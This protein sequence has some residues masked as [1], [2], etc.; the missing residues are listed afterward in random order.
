MIKL[1]LGNRSG[2]LLLLPFLIALYAL[3]ALF[4]GYHLPSEQGHFGFWN[5]Y[6]DE[7]SLLSRMSAPLLIFGSATLLN[8]LFN[9]NGFH[10][11]NVFLPSLIYVVFQSFFHSFYFLTGIGIATMFL[12]L[13]MWQLLKLDQ[14]TDGRKTVFNTAILF[15]IA[16]TFYPMLLLS[17]PFLFGMIWILRPFILRESGLAIIGFVIPLLYAGIYTWVMGISMDNS[18]FSSVSFEWKIPDIYVAGGAMVLIVLAG[19]SP[20]LT[21]INQSSIRL[22]KIFRVNAMLLLLFGLLAVIEVTTNGKIDSSSLGL[23][24]LLFIIMYGFGT[25]NPRPFNAIV[26][27]LLCA[28]SVSKFFISFNL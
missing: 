23:I 8:F 25:K 5:L 6:I 3:C 26:F 21:K 1:F 15:G 10:E 22:K 18:R 27:Y 11:K 16:T 14:N 24:P 2:V 13:A 19:L 9:R 12:I 4:S 20:L 7:D 28:F 17:I